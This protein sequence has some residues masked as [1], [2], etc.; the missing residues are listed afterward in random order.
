L[1]IINYG[2]AERTNIR[3]ESSKKHELIIKITVRIRIRVRSGDWVAEK[4]VVV[5]VDIFQ[6]GPANKIRIKL[7]LL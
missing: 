3:V 5:F 7:D 4:F 2:R 1:K 6:L